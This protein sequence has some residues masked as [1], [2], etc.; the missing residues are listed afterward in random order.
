M[1][2]SVRDCLNN[3]YI[4]SQSLFEFQLH[5]TTNSGG[6]QSAGYLKTTNPNS[7]NYFRA[8]W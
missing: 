5:A 4:L 2:K 1:A 8:Y 7:M 3:R 6:A